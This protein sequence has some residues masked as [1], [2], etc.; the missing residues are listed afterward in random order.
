MASSVTS[1]GASR[2]FGPLLDVASSRC[3][4][5]WPLPLALGPL[6]PMSSGIG[7]GADRPA[8]AAGRGPHGT[9]PRSRHGRAQQRDDDLERLSKRAKIR[10][11]GSPN[12]CACPGHTCPAPR[13]KTNRPAADLVEGLGRL[14][15]DARVPVERR[16][17][18]CPDLDRRGR[19]RHGARHRDAVPRALGRTV[20]PSH[21]S[22]SGIQ[23]VSTPIASAPRAM[24]RSTG[25]RVVSRSRPL[26]M[27]GSTTPISMDRMVASLGAPDTPSLG[28]MAMPYAVPAMTTETTDTGPRIPLAERVLAERVRVV[29]PS[30]IRRFFDI[31]AT[32]TTSSA[33]ASASPTSTRRG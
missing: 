26:C 12:A 19:R 3:P 14:G 4:R 18:P 17:D 32:W 6:P 27:I 10:S 13:P 33:S 16:Q 29:P 22:S 1:R 9:R 11:S 30:G 15:D 28:L 23:T 20:L 25:Q 8:A 21:R 24:S 2:R 31:A 5:A 7:S